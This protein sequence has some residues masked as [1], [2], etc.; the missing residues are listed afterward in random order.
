MY[1]NEFLGVFFSNS[2]DN[3][4]FSFQS[5]ILLN[6][7]LYKY[8]LKKTKEVHYTIPEIALKNSDLGL[9]TLL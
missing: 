4:Y 3:L 2:L 5:S 9:V 1:T 7:L 8:I 6:S